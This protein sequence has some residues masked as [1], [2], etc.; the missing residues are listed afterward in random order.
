MLFLKPLGQLFQAAHSGGPRT[1]PGGPRRMFQVAVSGN[2]SGSHGTYLSGGYNTCCQTQH[3]RT[4]SFPLSTNHQFKNYHGSRAMSV[5]NRRVPVPLYWGQILCYRRRS[6]SN[7]VLSERV[8][9]SPASV[10]FSRTRQP[11]LAQVAVSPN[12]Y[13]YLN[14]IQTTNTRKT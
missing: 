8:L 6:R 4:V 10:P 1:G 12:H 13:W 7:S 11:H 9:P 3:T 5:W 14:L 2:S